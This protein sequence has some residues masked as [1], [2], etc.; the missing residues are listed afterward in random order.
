M[1]R[2]NALLHP[3]DRFAQTEA[4]QAKSRAEE[5]AKQLH[6][7]PDGIKLDCTGDHEHTDTC[8][9]YR[10]HDFRRSFATLNHE[11][12]AS[13]KQSQTGHSSHATTQ[14]YEQFAKSQENFAGKIYLPP[15][16]GAAAGQ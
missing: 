4:Q 11:L 8:H 10:L 3:R 1:A 15:S 9:F 5:S 12:P 14:R 2:I 13:L 16:M 7:A 6:D